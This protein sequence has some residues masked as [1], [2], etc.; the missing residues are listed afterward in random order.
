MII[1]MRVKDKS[2]RRFEDP[3][4]KGNSSKCIFY[5]AVD[6]VAEGIPMDTNPRD[7]NTKTA[8]AQDIIDS[9]ES[10]DGRFHLLNRGIVCCASDVYYNNRTEEV[11]IDFPDDKYGNVDGGHT[12]TIVCEH[13][14][15]GL[16]NQYVQF[17]VIQGVDGIIDALAEARNTSVPVDEKSLAELRSQFDPIKEAIEGMP[18]YNR[19]A[20]KQNQKT[21]DSNNKVLKMIDARE[22]VAIASM[23]NIEVYTKEKHPTQ[24]YASKAKIL[25]QYL[26]NPENMRKFVNVLP[27]IFDLYDTIECEFPEAYNSNNCKFGRKKWSNYKDGA[28]VGQSKF[29]QTD[30]IYRVPEGIMYPTVA[31]F[32]CLLTYNSK[33]EKYEWKDGNCPEKIWNVC[34]KELTRK[35]MDFASSIG[36]NPNTVGKDNNIWYLA[37]I[38]VKENA[39]I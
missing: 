8:V 21:K 23:F 32:R 18:F 37:Y 2:F 7:R 1:S 10:N 27:D 13:K 36:D 17:E 28:V 25:E 30:L 19:I 29:T 15:T 9:L 31:A 6:D 33:T 3:T 26:E 38:T 11:R 12:Y 39:D 24:A 14:N 20:F 22:V 34:K 35:I 5:V 16:T 4:G